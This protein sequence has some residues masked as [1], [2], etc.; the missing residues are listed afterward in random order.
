MRGVAAHRTLGAGWHHLVG[1]YDGRRLQLFLDGELA[2]E[3]SASGRL[4]Q[5]EVPVTL[6]DLGEGS[7]R[8]EGELAE[9][10]VSSVARTADWIEAAYDRLSAG[11]KP[12]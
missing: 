11:R 9:T 3:R 8:F 4:V 6:G 5:S 12:G 1:V 10:Q 2:A 7:A